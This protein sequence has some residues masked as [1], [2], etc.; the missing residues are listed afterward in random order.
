MH[1]QVPPDPAIATWAAPSWSDTR[2]LEED[3]VEH[4][5]R[6]G[7]LHPAEDTQTLTVDVVQ[8]D[9]V[10]LGTNPVSI[11]RAPAVISMAGIRLSP[12]ETRTLTEL[13]TSALTTIGAIP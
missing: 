8:R 1:P 11:R 12:D 4:R 7:D 5:R 6:V 9:E 13:L 3:S 2:E 10:N